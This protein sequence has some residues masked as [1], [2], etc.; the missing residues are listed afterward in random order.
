M[1]AQTPDVTC[2]RAFDFCNL[3]LSLDPTLISSLRML[4]VTEKGPGNLFNHCHV[5]PLTII[6]S[7]QCKYGL[8]WSSRGG[9]DQ[10][11]EL[12]NIIQRY[13]YWNVFRMGILSESEH[14]CFIRL[15]TRINLR[16]VLEFL[17]KWHLGCTSCCSK[18]FCWK[19]FVYLRSHIS[20]Q[21]RHFVFSFN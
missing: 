3:F 16:R 8:K 10:S 11:G 6:P 14:K 2:V 9:F 20:S 1:Q 17:P 15:V 5:A 21:I 19:R 12:K 4:L 18:Y 13:K 7:P